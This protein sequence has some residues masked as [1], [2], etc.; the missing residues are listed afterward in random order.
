MVYIGVRRG[1]RMLMDMRQELG[2]A[3][4]VI[5]VECDVWVGGDGR[6]EFECGGAHTSCEEVLGWWVV[7][8]GVSLEIGG[9]VNRYWAGWETLGKD[10]IGEKLSTRRVGGDLGLWIVESSVERM[11]GMGMLEEI[12]RDTLDFWDQFTEGGK[13][14]ISSFLLN[15]FTQTIWIEISSQI[16]N[17][18]DNAIDNAIPSLVDASVRSYM[19]GHILHVH[20]A[21]VQSS[22]VPEQQHQLYL[23]MKADPLL[24]QQDIAIWLALQMKFE[25]TQVPQTA[26]RSSAV[27]TRDQDDPHDDAHPEGENSAKRQKTSEY[28]AYVSGE[29]SSGQVNVEEPG[30]STSGNQEQDDEFDFWTD[31]YASDDDEIPTKQVTQDIMEEISLTIDEAKLKKMADEMLRQRCT[32]GDEHQYHID[33]MKNFLQSDIVWESRKEILVSP[34]PRKITPLVQSCQRDPEAPALSLINQDLLYLKKGNSGPEKIVLSLHKFPAIV[35]ND[36]D[37]EERTSRWVNK[38]IKKFNPYARYGVENWK[39]PHAKIFYIRR[40]K[41]PGRPKEEIYSNSKI[42]QVIKTYWELGHEHKFITEIVARR[43]NDCIVSITEPDYKNLNKNDIEDMY[44]LIVNNKVP[45]YANTGLLWSLSVFIRSSVIWERVHDFQLGIES[46]QQKINLTAPTITFPGIEEYDV[47]SIVY[48]PVHGIIYTNSKKEKRVMRHSEIHKFCDA[49]LR[50][51]LEGLKSYYND[52][53]YGYVQKELTNDEVE[54][55]KLFEEEIEVRLNYRD[56]M[57]RWEMYVNGRPLG[58]RRER[59]E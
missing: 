57:R 2:F 52:V 59:P 23:A 41:E 14:I 22:S 49:T 4:N 24:Q 54:F 39:N 44:L 21:Q 36:D 20:P 56:Q 50:R 5:V 19:S 55:L 29:S 35:F 17:A 30:P 15:L 8:G 42:V 12:M 46:Y 45:D 31:S 10:G 13:L 58:P 25:K 43:A 27:R 1:E 53:K 3:G 37:I 51:T 9:F 33:Q 32:S 26:C 16:Q 11:N 47:F 40:Q 18:I 6:D 38:C 34:H 48:E 28:E 7:Q